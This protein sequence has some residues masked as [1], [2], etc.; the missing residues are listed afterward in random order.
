MKFGEESKK[1]SV[2]EGGVGSV[3]VTELVI[4]FISYFAF[5]YAKMIIIFSRCVTTQMS[6]EIPL[7]VKETG[8]GLCPAV[9]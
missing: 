9:N 7:L 2:G 8:K 5:M 4:H 6:P 3:G 1:L